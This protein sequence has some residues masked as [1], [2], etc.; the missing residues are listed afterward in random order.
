MFS[1]T[2]APFALVERSGSV[3]PVLKGIGLKGMG[4][5]GMGLKDT[6]LKG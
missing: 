5:K 1:V 3:W 4:L 2:A 6:G